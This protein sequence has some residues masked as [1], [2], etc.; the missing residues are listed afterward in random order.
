MS[1]N[2]R[3]TSKEIETLVSS[4]K[5][6]FLKDDHLWVFGSRVD[7]TKRGGDIDLYIESSVPEINNLVKL[8]IK[9]L[10]DVKMQI[11]E[12]KIDIILNH[13]PSK[14]RAGIYEEASKTGV[15]L[16]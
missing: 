5:K 12:Q 6:F 14:K 16:V 15:K 11:G 10:V 7:S 9:F 4:F 8:K 2:L 1:K 3:L 13:L